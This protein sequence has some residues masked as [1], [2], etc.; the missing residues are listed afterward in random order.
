VIFDNPE[1][2]VELWQHLMANKLFVN[3]KRTTEQGNFS[4]LTKPERAN[5]ALGFYSSPTPNNVALSNDPFSQAHNRETSVSRLAYQW[6]GDEKF[7]HDFNNQALSREWNESLR[8]TYE[9]EGKII[10]GWM[11]CEMDRTFVN[12]HISAGVFNRYLNCKHKQSKSKGHFSSIYPFKSTGNGLALARFTGYLNF[13]EMVV[14]NENLEERNCDNAIYK[15]KCESQNPE[16]LSEVIRERILQWSHPSSLFSYTRLG[17]KGSVEGVVY[18]FGTEFIFN[19][20]EIS[21]WYKNK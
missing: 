14:S 10:K 12:V 15:P 6:F 3:G 5:L 8:A 13:D 18:Y 9:M 17:K 21:D 2:S 1:F 20:D 16:K 7:I 19:L 11:N 4:G